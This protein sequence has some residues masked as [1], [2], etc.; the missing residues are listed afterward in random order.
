LLQTLR[1]LDGI[2]LRS[3]GHNTPAYIHTLVEAL[4]LAFADR[5]AYYGDPKF[6]DVPID[7]LLSDAYTSGRRARID[8]SR[9]AG[10][11]ARGDTEGA[12]SRGARASR[13]AGLTKNTP[14]PILTRPSCVLSIGTATRS[15]PRPVMGR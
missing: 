8:P 12:R 11:A 3:L 7:A 6:V 2:D 14:N 13:G 1:I 15:P 4:K 9:V 5:H 10:N